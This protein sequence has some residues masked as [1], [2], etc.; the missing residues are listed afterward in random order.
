M[1]QS[2]LGQNQQ[3]VMTC[4]Y[5]PRLLCKAVSWDISDLHNSRSKQMG[6]RGHLAMLRQAHQVMVKRWQTVL[7]EL[8]MRQ[9]I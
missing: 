9:T 3:Q 2:I 7:Q 1:S 6:C 4:T 5:V 8:Q